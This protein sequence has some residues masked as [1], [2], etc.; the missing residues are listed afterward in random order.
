[1]EP[2][3]YSFLAV[4]DELGGQHAI[5]R[6]CGFVSVALAR[7]GHILREVAP[8]LALSCA[9]CLLDRWLESLTCMP[10]Q[11]WAADCAMC[12]GKLLHQSAG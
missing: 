9:G 10:G 12:L 8:W 6:V 1:M 7:G 5:L 11:I 3:W 2:E 4:E